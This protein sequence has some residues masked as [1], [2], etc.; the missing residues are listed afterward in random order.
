M[1]LKPRA[2]S[3][4]F[5]LLHTNQNQRL[6]TIATTR[7]AK[8]RTTSTT[9]TMSTS[10]GQQPTTSRIFG[11]I[12]G[13]VAGSVYEWKNCK[14]EECEIFQRGSDLTDDSILTLA[15]ANRFLGTNFEAED[16]VSLYSKLYSDFGTAYPHA[17][18][19]GTFSQWMYRSDEDRKPYNSWGNGSAMRASPIGWVGFQ[20]IDQAL[21]EAARSAQVTHN[22]P[23]G[24]KGAQAVVAAIFLARQGA[25]KHVIQSYVEQHC[26]YD[27]HSRTLAEIRPSYQFDVSCDGS[28]PQAIIAFLE[29]K[30]FED[31]IRKA[32]SLGGDSDTIACI[33]AS[34][35]Q[36]FYGIDSI[37]RYMVEYC[38]A[39]MDERQLEI[40]D[41]FWERYEQG[42]LLI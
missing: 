25:S 4:L 17:G 8:T 14:S 21:A 28:V 31:A 2:A 42:T 30:D 23:S 1:I 16:A 35:A 9:I 10:T 15:T 3:L 13:D 12:V 19:G 27:L 33:A 20:N 11:A 22:H 41:T 32:I 39:R 24:I 29:S 26:G 36:A 38:R 6:T 37:P 7:I 40:M 5:V 34:I 18:Y